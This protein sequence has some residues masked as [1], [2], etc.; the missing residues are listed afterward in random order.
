MS[1]LID[2]SGSYEDG[3]RKIISNT[4]YVFG[5]ED[6]AVSF[7]QLQHG[8]IPVLL[9]LLEKGNNPEAEEFYGAL[10]TWGSL[11]G[12]IMDTKNDTGTD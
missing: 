9:K 4:Q 8:F 2:R 11:M 7:A 6:G 12:H 1:S 3:L 5:G 10:C